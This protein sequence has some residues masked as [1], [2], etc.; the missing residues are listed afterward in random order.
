[1]SRTAAS[2]HPGMFDAD[3]LPAKISVCV[4]RGG[5]QLRDSVEIFAG[6]VNFP[7]EGDTGGDYVVPAGPASV[8]PSL[9]W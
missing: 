2:G 6:L 1:M 5:R 3:R 4:K 8:E 9:R 7:H